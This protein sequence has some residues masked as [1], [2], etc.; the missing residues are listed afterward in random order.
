[1]TQLPTIETTR[2]PRDGKRYLVGH[3]VNTDGTTDL[4]GESYWLVG[5]ERCDTCHGT[6]KQL[7]CID[8]H[9]CPAG[10]LNGWTPTNGHVIPARRPGGPDKEIVS[11]TVGPVPV[12]VVPAEKEG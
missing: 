10:C 3:H 2:L 6:G 7:D 12:L 9:A 4:T 1:M 5:R 11:V 8:D